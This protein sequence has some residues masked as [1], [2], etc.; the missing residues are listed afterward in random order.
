MKTQNRLNF[1]V[2]QDNIFMLKIASP[3]V[4]MRSY[5]QDLQILSDR[6]S[7]KA[8]LYQT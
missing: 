1:E 6:S 7:L 2:G 5:K 4:Q 8:H 3:P